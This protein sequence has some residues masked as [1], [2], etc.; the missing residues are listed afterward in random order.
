LQRALQA[1]RDAQAG[2]VQGQFPSEVQPLVDDFNG[3]LDHNEAVVERARSQAGNLAHALKTPLSVLEQAAAQAVG[4]AQ[5]APF[6]RLVQE[7]CGTARRHI[8]WHLARARVAATQRVPGHQ[9]DVGQVLSGLVRVMQKVHAARGLNIDVALGDA[10]LLF[11][12]EAQDLHE[13][14][15]N[16]I[17]NACKWAS[18]RVHI[19]AGLSAQKG[20]AVVPDMVSILIED[21]GPGIDVA[22]RDAVM[23]RGVRLDETVPGSGLGLAIAKDL[24]DLY[25]GTLDLHPASG[26]GLCVTVRL[27]AAA[28]PI[29]AQTRR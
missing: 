14:L 6:A 7:Q 26:G 3:V 8:D 23:A 20:S 25:G 5:S 10:S 17:D 1:V 4:V 19:Q 2:R 29:E 18:T 21:D 15:G 9:T 22:Q 28:T 13:V 11:A 12:G 27:P 24:V 16:V